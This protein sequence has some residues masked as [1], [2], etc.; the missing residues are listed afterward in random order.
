MHTLFKPK[1]RL[2]MGFGGGFSPVWFV[3]IRRWFRW[4]TLDAWAYKDSAEEQ[5]ERLRGD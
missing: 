3:Q 1:Y 2:R 5:L 4:E